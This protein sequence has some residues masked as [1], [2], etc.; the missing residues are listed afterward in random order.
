[1]GLR[2]P[3]PMTLVLAI[4]VQI[5]TTPTRAD[6]L[7]QV[8]ERA[9]SY[10]VDYTDAFKNILASE[11][12]RQTLR[13]GENGRPLLR[14]TRADV[15][16]VTLPGPVPWVT[17]RDVRELDG[18]EV[19]N[20]G[21]R[22]EKLFRDSPGSAVAQA[23]ALLEESSRYNLG[24]LRRMVNV[25]TLAL[26][27]L[28]ADTRPR[29][30]FERKREQT[31]DGVKTVEVA[32]EERSRPTLVRDDS[33]N[34][35]PSSGR[36]WIDPASG[37]VLRTE[38]SYKYASG[39][40]GSR[41]STAR[42]ITDYRRDAKVGILVPVEMQER[43]EVEEPSTGVVRPPK[44]DGSATPEDARDSEN[45]RI[46]ATARYSAYHRFEIQTQEIFRA[47]PEATPQ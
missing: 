17:F 33:G 21:V 41:A 38:V 16:V 8:L 20:R 35:V 28:Q 15:M 13:T 46:E 40:A 10:V 39:K 23:R 7:Q 25:P 30:A 32:F 45:I 27:F 11:E 6:D 29:F 34:D 4:L 18:H 9:G 2:I 14:V 24:P 36:L 22:L 31:I 12:Y 44:R 47:A 1:M 5:A 3:R 42:V 43:Y 37:S 19:G 26:L